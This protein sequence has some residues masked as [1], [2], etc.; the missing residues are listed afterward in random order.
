MGF[1]T[2]DD[3][4]VYKISNELAI[5]QTVD[6]ITPLVNDPYIFGQIAAANSLSDIFAMGAAFTSAL[7]I[8]AYDSCHITKEML[9]EIL[10]GGSDKVKEAGGFILGGH[11]VEDLEMKYGLSVTGHVHPDKILRNNTIKAGDKIILTKPIGTGVITTAIKADMAPE[12]VINEAVSH[13]TFLNKTAA[14]I[15]VDFGYVNGMTD[16]TGFG[17]IGHLYEMTN[18]MS[19]INLYSEEVEFIEGAFEL[20]SLGLFP[21]GSYNCKKNFG[22]SVE[23]ENKNLD[24]DKLML[25]YDV[26]TSGGLLISVAGDNAEK[27][28]DKIKL[29]GIERAAIIGEV[30]ESDKRKIRVF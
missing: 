6:F 7:N 13:M 16:V 21:G 19:S 8:V 26:Q 10:K 4:G 17:L 29:A 27:L 15:A 23:V 9:S 24:K 14:E 22:K 3:A 11:T 28:L 25:M 5:V 1:N 30:V 18:S 12:S 20:A 2:S